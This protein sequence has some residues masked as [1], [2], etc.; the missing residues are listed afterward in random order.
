MYWRVGAA[1]R[2]RARVANKAAFHDV[3]LKGPPP[4]LIAFHENPAVGWRQLTPRDTPPWLDRS[5]RI[6][7]VDDLPVRSISCFDVRKCYRR[8]V[9]ASALIE[10]AVDGEKAA[11][12][13]VLEAYAFDSELT[14]SAS[15]TG[16]SSTFLRPG[17]DI[18]ARCVPAR[19]IMRLAGDSKPHLTT[20]CRAKPLN[21][22]MVGHLYGMPG[23]PMIR[24]SDKTRTSDWVRIAK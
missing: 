6:G 10:A 20:S 23:R 22:W 12:A 13:A 15:S 21:S 14:P 2:Q 18:M 16:Y 8:R 9:V 5:S 17:F 4:G 7:R 19:P 3:V 11:G 24:F 1:Y